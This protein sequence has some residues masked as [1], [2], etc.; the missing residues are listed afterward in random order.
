MERSTIY[1]GSGDE[2]WRSGALSLVTCYVCIDWIGLLFDGASATKFGWH[3]RHVRHVSGSS[4]LET[5]STIE[6]CRRSARASVL[7]FDF[8]SFNLPPHPIEPQSLKQAARKQ[9]KVL[10]AQSH[11]PP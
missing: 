11:T 7:D 3:V 10:P 6:V 5:S 8:R 4:E 2:V 1:A 9:H